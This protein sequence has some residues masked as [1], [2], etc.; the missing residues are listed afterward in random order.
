LESIALPQPIGKNI[1]FNEVAVFDIAQTAGLT[2]ESK[3]YRERI[4]KELRAG[5]TKKEINA[6][7]YA[8]LKQAV[9]N[10]GYEISEKSHGAA[11]GG[12]AHE[13]DGKKLIEINQNNADS[14]K[15]STLL[16]EFT[17]HEAGHTKETYTGDRK[18]AEIQAE[19]SA[20]I[21]GKKFGYDD[22]GAQNYIASFAQK[23]SPEEIIKEMYYS[24]AI[25]DAAGKKIEKELNKM[26]GIELYQ[27]DGKELTKDELFKK[28]HYDKEFIKYVAL[29][30]DAQKIFGLKNNEGTLISAVAL[31]KPGSPVKTPVTPKTDIGGR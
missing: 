10:L 1:T 23:K 24:A 19:T 25:A 6:V 14:E 8:D 13:S 22:I 31:H 4:M 9:T 3:E 21:L 27:Y 17:H 20:Y 28:A 12:S 5:E 11:L 30:P 29:S 18:V 15:V 26:R 16:H 7:S 2:P